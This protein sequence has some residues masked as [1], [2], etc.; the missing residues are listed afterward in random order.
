MSDTQDHNEK[1]EVILRN[2]RYGLRLFAVYVALY[3]GF[4]FLAVFRPESMSQ[5]IMGGVNLAIVY[6]FTLIIAALLLAVIYTVLCRR[7]IS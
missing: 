4:I 1:P 2:S 3:G 5:P 7:N 6:G